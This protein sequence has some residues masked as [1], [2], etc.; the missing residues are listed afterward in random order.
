MLTV[1]TLQ[2]LAHNS[3]IFAVRAASALGKRFG[4][5][6]KYDESQI[7]EMND[8]NYKRNGLIFFATDTDGFPNSKCS[9]TRNGG[10]IV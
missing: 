1:E 6:K 10:D 5:T 7:C 3:I 4:K 9:R 2:C 8:W